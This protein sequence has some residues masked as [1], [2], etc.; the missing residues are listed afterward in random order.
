MNTSPF[1]PKLSPHEMA[2]LMDAARRRA[3][4]ARR[5]AIDAFWSAAFGHLGAAWRA[6]SRAARLSTAPLRTTE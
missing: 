3:L 5:E 1:E 6:L 2:A 4:Q